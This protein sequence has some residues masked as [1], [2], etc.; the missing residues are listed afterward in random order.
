MRNIQKKQG[1]SEKIAVFGFKDS[2][3]GQVLQMLTETT[4]CQVEFFL[5]LNELPTLD[6]ESERNKITNKKTEYVINNQI[7]GKPIYF[8]QDYIKRLKENEIE[9]VLI[10]EDDR[11]LRKTIFDN[12]RASN[13]Q[14]IS[15]IHPSV[16]LGGHNT[17]GDG[18]IIFPNCYIGYKS[19]IGNGT[20]IQSNTVIEHHNVIG[21]FVDVNPRLTTGGFTYIGD[22]SEINIS[23][24]IIN[25]IIIEDSVQIGA[26][27]LVLNDCNSGMLYYGRP[28]KRIRTR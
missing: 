22:F 23:V 24:D 26:G 5:T 20:I 4:S 1:Q 8:D 19:D 18:V 16:F 14:V 3:V 21:N 7:F 10:L 11:H 28:A 25:R 13:I 6:I 12:V 9:K 17:L 27:S 15:F 2:L